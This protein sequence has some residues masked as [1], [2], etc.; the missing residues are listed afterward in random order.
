[1]RNWYFQVCSGSLFLR[2]T[3]LLSALLVSWLVVAPI[4]F[5]LCGLLGVAAATVAAAVCL[6]AAAAALAV[7]ELFGPGVGAVVGLLLAMAMRT[8]VPLLFVILSQLHGGVLKP[9]GLIYD[10]VLFYFL[11]L[12]VEVP[13]SIARGGSRRGCPDD[14]ARHS[15]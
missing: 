7:G 14:I 8:G 4:S 15:V 12:A 2:E 5:W 9:A 3:V 11:A 13:L 10:V 1:M 6:A